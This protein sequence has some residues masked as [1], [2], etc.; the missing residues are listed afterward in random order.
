[1]ACEYLFSI[2][3]GYSQNE[4][5]LHLNSESVSVPGGDK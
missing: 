3:A 5:K 1:M 4:M 2:L